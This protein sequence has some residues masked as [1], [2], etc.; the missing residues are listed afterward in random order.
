MIAAENK[1]F[2]IY[3]I[4]GMII[5]YEEYHIRPFEVRLSRSASA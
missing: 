2:E 4:Q 5:F 3:K 1:Q